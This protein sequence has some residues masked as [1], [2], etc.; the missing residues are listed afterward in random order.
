MLEFSWQQKNDPQNNARTVYLLT[1]I[2]MFLGAIVA[3]MYY[4]PFFDAFS[5]KLYTIGNLI[6]FIAYG[7]AAMCMFVAPPSRAQAV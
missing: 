2:F 5:D 6:S 4:I 3:A 1:A 7:M